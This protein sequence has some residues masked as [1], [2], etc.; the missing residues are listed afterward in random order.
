MREDYNF[1]SQ[2]AT[3]NLCGPPFICTLCSSSLSRLSDLWRHHRTVHERRY[4]YYC[5]QCHKGMQNKTEL[6]RHVLRHGIELK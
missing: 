6:R 2:A 5:P 1:G 4:S 3:I